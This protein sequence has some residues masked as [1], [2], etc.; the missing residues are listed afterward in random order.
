MAYLIE[1]RGLSQA[2]IEKYRLGFDG[3]RIWIPVFKDGKAVNVRRY[4]KPGGTGEKILNMAG[5]GALRIYP[6]DTLVNQAVYLCEGE[7]DALAAIDRGLPALTLTGGAGS[8]PAD[9][10]E[11]FRGKDVAILYD[12][13]EAGRR[14]ALKAAG[15]LTGIAARIRIVN[16]GLAENGDDVTDWF[17]KYKR[18]GDD[19]KAL[20]EA[21]PEFKAGAESRTRNIQADVLGVHL[22]ETGEGQYAYRRL[23]LKFHIAGKDLAPYL[24]P[25][26]VNWN[27]EMGHKLCAF[28]PLA[29]AQGVMTRQIDE[30]SPDEILEFLD[31][32]RATL[33]KGIRRACGIPEKCPKPRL[34]IAQ[35]QNVE[36]LRAIPDLDFSFEGRSYTIRNLFFMGHGV[37]PNR[38]YDVEGVALPEPKTQSATM[39]IYEVKESEDS[40]GQFQVTP[41]FIEEQ[42]I[43]SEG[44]V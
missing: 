34:E 21:S 37:E 33:E 7:W 36:V 8:F 3:D 6:E 40:L 31:A 30:H 16:L 5:S 29:K 22:V 9:L 42:K 23:K 11:P 41:E 32:P 25:Q 13:D 4:R 12:C 2:T 28:C 1:K 35:W 26:V 44:L 10:A 19:L 43:F 17:V 14:G 24:V 38:T 39:L 20:V 18:S 15:R 27:C